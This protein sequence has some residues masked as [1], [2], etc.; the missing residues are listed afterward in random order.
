MED[1]NKDK[2]NEESNT[3][4]LQ[5]LNQ[6]LFKS[7]QRKGDQIK[8]NYKFWDTQP[9]PKITS[10][11]CS[12]IGPIDTENDIEKERQEAYKLPSNFTWYDVDINDNNDLTKVKLI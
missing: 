3:E 10:Q 9:V 2:P 5:S 12:E 7:G 1:T 6:M 4:I 8:D 11:E